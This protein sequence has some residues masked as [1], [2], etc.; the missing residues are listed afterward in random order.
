MAENGDRPPGPTGGAGAGWQVLGKKV[1]HASRWM[2]LEQWDVRLPDGSRIPDHHVITFPRPAV[3]VVPFGADGRLLLIDHY[4]F[5]TDTRGWEIPAGAAEPGESV[6][7]TARRELLEE[8]GC[9]ALELQALGRYHPTNGSS[10]Q[11]FHVTLARGVHP[12]TTRVD[13]NETLGLRWFSRAEVKA[14]LIDGQ[15]RDG[16]SLTGLL[17]AL[18]ASEAAPAGD[19]PP[20]P[21]RAGGEGR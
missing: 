12:V 15:I 1:L 17:W 9:E 2:N 5:Q 18:A 3:G 4:R 14:M 6:E 10:N 7:Q 16:L 19:R 11:V 13:P 20:P 8:T 21:R